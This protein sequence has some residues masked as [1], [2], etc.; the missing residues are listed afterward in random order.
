[1][2]NTSKPAK[3]NA[4]AAL[5]AAQPT[6]LPAEAILPQMEVEV[7]IKAPPAEGDEPA[8]DDTRARLAQ[9]FSH[10]K[11][12]KIVFVDDKAELQTDTGA[13]IKVL[14]AKETAREAL[15][16]FFPGV[17]LTLENDALQEQV[18]AR[19][20]ELDA[21]GLTA[22]RE[23]LAAQSDDAAEREALGRLQNLLPEATTT[24]LLTPHAWHEQR[25]ALIGEC[26]EECRTLFLFDQELEV[27]DATLGF[28]KGSDII[29]DMAE[30]EK[31]GFGTRWFCG[32][33]THT[34]AK[35]DEVTSWRQLAKSES[36]NLR[37]FMPIAKATLDDAPAFYGAVYRTLINTYCQTM[38]SLAQDAF[39]EALK[40]ALERF[41]DLDP[42]DFEHMVVNSSEVEGV[43]ELET[44]IR[45]YGIIQK[46]QVKSQ[47]LQQARVGEFAAAARAAK[48]IADIGRA[49][50]ATSQGRL[51]KLR[52]EELYESDQLVNSYNDP[53]RNGDL[54]EIG[55]GDDLKLWVLIAQPCDLMVRSNGKR[56]REENFKVAVLAPLRTRPLGD[57]AGVKDGLNFSLEHYDHG[58]AQ[59]AVVLLADA[60]PANLQVLDLVV[61]NKEGRCQLAAAPDPAMSLPSQA[62]ERRDA[63]LRNHFGKVT[64]QI[65]AART[66]HKDTVANLLSAAIIPRG[67]PKKAFAKYGAYDGGAFSYP[68]RRCGRIRD[69]LAAS[70]LTAYSR[71]LARDAY[72]H[73]FS[74]AE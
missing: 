22:L 66:A 7:G 28:A 12:T 27:N 19:L 21:E 37:F 63:E 35:G 40:D 53:L 14:V 6:E 30:K 59:S 20:S 72:E 47:I 71:F 57:E 25:D 69:P 8:A 56:V 15:A 74:K 11:I 55:E 2:A 10:L 62:W 45:L 31:A 70:L 32:M 3:A 44:L 4:A 24:H 39:E 54:F 49:L 26:T 50:S 1:M 52:R 60:T 34:V 43:S 51:H 16:N 64:R 65:E 38:K 58:G 41:A 13:V 36:L 29:R 5:I 33:L 46:D 61:F 42:I 67:A 18:A 23:V 68:I 48:D 9:L 17:V 73:D